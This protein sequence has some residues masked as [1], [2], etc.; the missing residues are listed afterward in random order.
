MSNAT[1]NRV[2]A[3]LA[4]EVVKAVKDHI[5]AIE[6]A[7]PFLVGLTTAERMMLPKI[8]VGNKVFTE[9]AIQAA[10]NNAVLLPSFIK[11]EDMKK[12]LALYHTLDELVLVVQQLAEKLADTQLL[13][14]S[15]AY[16]SALA[17]YKI[18]G[19]ASEAGVQGTKTLHEQL[20]QRFSGQGKTQVPPPESTGEVP[21][22]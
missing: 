3:T 11:V 18:F 20:K 12:D 1:V 10:V 15:E 22:T 6:K 17:I 21:N 4:P 19:A 13:A 9:D 14:G 2:N 8:N 5:I 7:L 16:T